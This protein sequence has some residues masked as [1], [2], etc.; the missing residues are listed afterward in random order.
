APADLLGQDRFAHRHPDRQ[1]GL[2]ARLTRYRREDRGV[3]G[4]HAVGAAGPDD[5]NVVHRVVATRPERVAEG[6]VGDDAGV[7]VDAAV[8]LG[9]ADDRDHPAGVEDPGVDQLDETGRV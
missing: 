3:R 6:P 7:V 1:A 5:G 2:V 8:A 9:L 4:E